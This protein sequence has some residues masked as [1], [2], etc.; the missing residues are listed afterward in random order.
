[1]VATSNRLAVEAAL[2]ALGEG[3]SAV[4]AAVAA[5]AV[6]GVVQPHS[7]GIGGDGFAL[8]AEPGQPVVGFNGSGAA[9]AALTLEQC[10]EPDAWHKR[11]ALVVTVPGVVDAWEQLLG[12]YGRLDLHTVLQPA[13]ELAEH[14]FPVGRIAAMEWASMSEHLRPGHGLPDTP[15]PGERVVQLPLAESLRAIA[16]GGRAAHMTSR[17]VGHAYHGRLPRPRGG[18]AP[19][20]RPG[21]GGAR[22]HGALVGCAGTRSRRPGR[23]RR[24]GARHP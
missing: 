1:M 4:D 5:D 12:R 6:L 21:R 11:S 23:R 2:W 24:G 15:Q 17:R 22:G 8:V 3:G 14:G 18:A 7:S 13:I 19:A 16:H 10:L 9:P 20:E